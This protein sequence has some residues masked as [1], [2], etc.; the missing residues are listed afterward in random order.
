MNLIWYS[1]DPVDVIHRQLTSTNGSDRV[2]SASQI[3]FTSVAKA[4]AVDIIINNS[5]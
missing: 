5:Y 1:I 3:L 4:A 2:R